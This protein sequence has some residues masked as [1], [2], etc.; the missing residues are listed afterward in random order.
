[1]SDCGRSSE[2]LAMINI[3]DYNKE[4]WQE[5]RQPLSVTFELTSRC[6]FS[7]VHCYLGQHRKEKDELTTAQIKSILDQLSTAGVL[8]VTF[9]GGECLLR[10]D[11]FE[12]YMYAKRLGF[13]V[14]LFTNAYT[15]K[16]EHFELFRTYPPFFVDVSIY[17][18]SDETYLEVTGVHNAFARVMKNCLLLKKY[19][20]A[21]GVKT[22]LFRQ[23]IA[24]YEK[25]CAIAKQ[26]DV[27]YRFAFALSPTIDHEY[28]P[29]TFMV[30]PE[31]MIRLEAED[32]V[33]REMGENYASVENNWGRAFD[34][35]KFVPLFIC[36]PGVNDLFIDYHG[37][38][39]PCASFR[40]AAIS[41]FTIP[42]EEIWERFS[43]YKKIPASSH[44][45]CMRCES[46]YY[47][48]VCPADQLQYN[49]DY[50]SVDPMVC[51]HAHARKRLFKD[52]MPITD[53]IR[54]L[55]TEEDK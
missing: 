46:R 9:T 42:F 8:F 20:I 3:S 25:M 23:N 21:F 38:A 53:V 32:P 11:F 12:I 26:L 48:R 15:L 51:A 14:C 39:M 55:E 18:A 50:E 13:M 47:C 40:S 49:G 7:C 33:Y 35:G 10:A 44:Y 34:N 2:Q 31:A 5:M 29:T 28:Y 22:P 45:R 43:V 52:H 36:N 16:D 17:G 4:L 30:R 37:R 24:D 27:K 54:L 1:M 19:G 6:N 41:M